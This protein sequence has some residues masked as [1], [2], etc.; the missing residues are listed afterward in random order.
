MF[1]SASYDARLPRASAV[2]PLRTVE[3]ELTT[4]DSVQVGEVICTVVEITRGEV[5][6]RVDPIDSDAAN[7]GG[8]AAVA[9]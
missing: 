1:D 2:D 4:G 9:R 7:V 6:L 3:I 8:V 5:H